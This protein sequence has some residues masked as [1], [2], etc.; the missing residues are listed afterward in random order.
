MKQIIWSYDSRIDDEAREY[1]QDTQREF[2]EDDGYEVS[3]E[4]WGMKSTGGSMTNGG[5]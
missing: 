2:L 4:E 3:D 5:T 1:Y